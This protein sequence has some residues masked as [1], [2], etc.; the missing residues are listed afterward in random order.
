MATRGHNTFDAFVCVSVGGGAT[1]RREAGSKRS[2][3]TEREGHGT[4]RMLDIYLISWRI[5]VV[6]SSRCLLVCLLSL[7]SHGRPLRCRGHADASSCVTASGGMG[8]TALERKQAGSQSIR[9]A[10]AAVHNTHGK[11]AQHATRTPSAEAARKATRNGHLK[12]PAAQ[13][14]RGG[15]RWAASTHLIGP[16]MS[17]RHHKQRQ[18]ARD[19]ELSRPF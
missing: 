12:P 17:L 3:P 11:P 16:R 9:K 18:E 13:C 6:G 19:G 4:A 15:L 2:R 1:A 7:V 8:T 5:T 10:G 14:E